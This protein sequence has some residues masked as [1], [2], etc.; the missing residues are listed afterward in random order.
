MNAGGLSNDVFH[1]VSTYTS[2]LESHVLDLTADSGTYGTIYKLRYRALNV[3]GAGDYSDV[4]LVALNSLPAAPATPTRVGAA[5]SETSIAVS[6]ASSQLDPELEGD[7][8][9]G[10]R[11]YAAREHSNIYELVHDG[12]GYPQ[13]RSFVYSGLIPGEHYDF[14]VSAINFNGEGPQS[15]IPLS[16]YSCT[17]PVGV[18]APVR[19]AAASTGTTTGLSWAEPAATGGCP[20]TGYALYRNDPAQ[21]DPA[22]GTEVFVEVNSD[23][24]SNIRNQPDLLAATVTYYDPSST[25]QAFKYVVEA[26]NAIG[27]TMGTSSSY[28]L[29]T[30]PPAPGLAPVSLPSLTSSTQITVLLTALTAEAETGGAPVTSYGLQMS[31]HSAGEAASFSDV[32]G[33]VSDSLAIQ[34]TVASVEKGKTY[35]FRYRAKNTYG[36]SEE[37]SPI[38]YEVAADAPDAPPAPSFVEASDTTATL[39]ISLPLDNGGQILTGIELWRDAGDLLESPVYALVDTYDVAGAG[40][41]HTLTVAADAIETGKVYSLRTRATNAKGA[42]GFSER[43]QI[44]VAAPPTAPAAPAAN[45]ALSSESSIHVAWAAL[46]PDG[47]RSPGGDITGYQLLMATDETGEDYI[48]VFDSVNLSTLVTEYQVGAPDHTLAAGSTVRFKVTAYNYNGA[49]SP[50]EIAALL[51]CG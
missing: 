19:V 23:N 6:W 7:A 16:T 3:E 49:G 42:S 45:Y 25:G 27:G 5:S 17:A 31:A 14:K 50:S 43:V 8:I 21:A 10:Y 51:I 28:T 29:A 2:G 22:T 11:L 41:T 39:A 26:I 30:V 12:A 35:A 46:S 37:W 13:V 15:T 20:L 32:T 36:W 33:T 18:P 47:S 44:A 24:D 4:A 9:T 1:A 40:P 48:V 38:M 34:H